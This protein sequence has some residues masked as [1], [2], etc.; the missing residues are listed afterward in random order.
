M[1]LVTSEPLLILLL[2]AAGV[3]AFAGHAPD[4]P[5]RPVLL[6]YALLITVL[7]LMTLIRVALAPGR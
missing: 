7:S 4:T 5:D 6:E 3:A 1:W 2:L